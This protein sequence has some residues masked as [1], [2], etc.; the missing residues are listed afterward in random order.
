MKYF[1]VGIFTLLASIANAAE[2]VIGAS[3]TNYSSELVRVILSL[4]AVL[5]I[6][7]LGATVFKKYMG[8]T[9][10]Q[11]TSIRMIGG[12]SI[13]A[14]EKLVVVEA[15]KVNLLL[16]VSAN[17]INK[18]HTFSENEFENAKQ[19]SSQTTPSFASHLE[20]LIGN[21]QS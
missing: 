5:A 21:K 12:L 20:K 3:V 1:L 8:G 6:F 18:L 16:G 11:N 14:K 19:D 10:K 17:G 9:I 2:P 7:V 13:G 4:A 15:G